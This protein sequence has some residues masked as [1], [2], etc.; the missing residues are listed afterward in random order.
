[1]RVTSLRS[2]LVS[3]LSAFIKK[4]VRF[5]ISD[6]IAYLKALEHKE[7]SIPKRSRWQEIVK[8]RGQIIKIKT[9]RTIQRISESK[10]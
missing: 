5:H 2:F 1:V 7:A 6:L 4:L 3:S 8:L 9:K 10:S